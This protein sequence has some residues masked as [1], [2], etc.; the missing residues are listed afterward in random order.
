MML[1]IKLSCRL[2]TWS[3]D[4]PSVSLDFHLSVSNVE[5]TNS[6]FCPP[7]QEISYIYVLF[8]VLI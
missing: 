3:L 1:E 7:I 4:T 6:K 8:C 5:D 2:S